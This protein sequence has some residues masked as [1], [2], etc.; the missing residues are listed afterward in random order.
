MKCANCGGQM[1]LVDKKKMPDGIYF[2]YKCKVCGH[3]NPK[4]A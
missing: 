3:T 4:K 1:I 2:I